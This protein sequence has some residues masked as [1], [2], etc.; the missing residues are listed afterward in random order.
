MYCISGFFFHT[1]RSKRLIRVFDAGQLV[2]VTTLYVLV[3]IRSPKLLIHPSRQ[4]FPSVTVNFCC[5]WWWVFS[6][7]PGLRFLWSMDPFVTIFHGLSKW[8]HRLFIILGLRAFTKY[9]QSQVHPCCCRR[10]FHFS[11]WLSE[12]LSHPGATSFWCMRL[13]MGI[14]VAC[15]S[16]RSLTI[17]Q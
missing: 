10:Q 4:L 16:W 15:W 2:L 12:S 6:P 3:G 17:L 7:G 14:F 9:D 13:S 5:W 11:L 1:G 8:H